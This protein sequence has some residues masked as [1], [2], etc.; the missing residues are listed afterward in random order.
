VDL[1]SM[2]GA[3]YRLAEGSYEFL[4]LASADPSISIW[5]DILMVSDPA[6][7]ICPLGTF[8][9]RDRNSCVKSPMTQT[10]ITVYPIYNSLDD[11]VTW[12]F[13]TRDS[14]LKS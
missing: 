8:T 4:N 13:D 12:S 5:K 3:Y 11:S 9:T 10:V 14:Q 7:L 1:S 2:L 6:L